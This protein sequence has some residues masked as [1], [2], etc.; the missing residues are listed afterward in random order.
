MRTVF[1][2]LMRHRAVFLLLLWI[3]ATIAMSFLSPYFLEFRTANYLLQFVPVLGLLGIGQTLIM[4]SG[5]PGI[6]LSIG[7]NLSLSS[8]FMG[9]LVTVGTNVWLAA[10]LCLI[11]AGLLG[12]INGIV[13]NYVGVPSLMATLATLF[14]YGGLALALTNGIPLSGFPSHFAFL[15]QGQTFGLPNQLIFVFIPLALLLHFLLTRT[16]WGNHIYA[17]GNNEKAAY[18]FGIKVCRLRTVLYTLGGVLAGI[19]AVITNSWFLTA[20]P[21]AGSGMELMSVTIAVMGGTHIFGGE[22]RVPGTVI[23]ILIVVTLQAGLQLANIS[24][25]W[26]LGIIGLLLIGSILLNNVVARRDPQTA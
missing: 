22:G 25:A 8:I 11:F 3:I 15:G 10:F 7:A 5:G 20:R 1:A 13:I 9:F 2:N 14:V 19:G 16:V 18:L 4:L 26:Q 23:A 24:A 6:D 12:L 21:D 17:A